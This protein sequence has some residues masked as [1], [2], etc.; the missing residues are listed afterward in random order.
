MISII[1]CRKL[2]RD[3]RRR[4]TYVLSAFGFLWAMAGSS[5]VEQATWVVLAVAAAVSVAVAVMGHRCGHDGAGER[6]RDLPEGWGRSV[7]VVNVVQILAIAATVFGLSNI[8]G[9][10]LIP[11]MVC[12]IVGL[13]FIPLARLYDQPQ[14]RWTAGLLGLVA[15]V[16]LGAVLWGAESETV[17]GGVG[18]AAAVTLWG[19][20]THVAIR[21]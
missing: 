13:H 4:G 15:V 5:I 3:L 8:G 18:F 10:S 1:E 9:A 16:G 2:D 7:G 11:P 12:L 21:N 14:Y 6:R 17:L 20:A 19:S